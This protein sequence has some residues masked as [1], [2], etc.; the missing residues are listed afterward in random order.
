MYKNCI[1]IW[2]LEFWIKM[3]Q[4]K[5]FMIDPYKSYE[6]KTAIET[7]VATTAQFTNLVK[8]LIVNSKTDKTTTVFSE[9]SLTK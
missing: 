5:I 6:D 2:I 8:N 4:L 9:I 7:S 3:T 1:E